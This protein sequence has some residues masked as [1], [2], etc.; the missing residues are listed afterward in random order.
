MSNSNFC[1]IARTGIISPVNVVAAAAS[2][3]KFVKAR[4][5]HMSHW[6]HIRFRRR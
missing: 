6:L 4:H 2:E 3:N 1:L 5:E